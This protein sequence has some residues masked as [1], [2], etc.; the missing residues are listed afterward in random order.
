[1]TSKIWLAVILLSKTLIAEQF[2]IDGDRVDLNIRES[3]G[4]VLIDSLSLSKINKNIR[5]I[6]DAITYTDGELQIINRGS[7][8]EVNSTKYTT[9]TK[10]EQIEGKLFTDFYL[11]MEALGY[12]IKGRTIY[13]LKYRKSV[14]ERVIAISP[15]VT[16]NI[17]MLGK[18]D[19]L[20]GADIYSN[21]NLPKVGSQLAP[22]IE[23]ILLLRP[24]LVVAESHINNR[25]LEVISK[26]G[27]KVLYL[28]AKSTED[29]YKN[30]QILG[31]KIGASTEGR[32]LSYIM[33]SVELTKPMVNKKVYYAL[34]TG[35]VDYTMGKESVFSNMAR[36]KGM[37]NV[38]DKGRGWSISIEDI[39]IENPDI[40]IANEYN[41]NNM[42]RYSKY[43]LIRAY[44]EGDIFIVN[45]DI[46]SRNTYRT[47]KEGYQ[48]LDYIGGLNE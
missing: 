40:I 35:V 36:I 10:V 42:G 15:S 33:Q 12:R 9:V 2:T 48:I 39:I 5:V 3:K 29:I 34:G 47:I 7:T 27:I 46:F 38:G 18:T 45:E 11:M 22:D 17:E 14:R 37:I 44:R 13:K 20:V 43:N 23:A 32:V 16:E 24:T 41:I 26:L 6:G 19:C 21:V 8:I 30:L 25:Y 1:M 31:S 28:D 4:L